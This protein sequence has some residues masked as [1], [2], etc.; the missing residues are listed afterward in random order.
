MTAAPFQSR[1]WSGPCDS[2]AP[3]F[4]T[5]IVAMRM[6]GAYEFAK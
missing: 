2:H 4:S 3:G 1:V 6:A 5:F